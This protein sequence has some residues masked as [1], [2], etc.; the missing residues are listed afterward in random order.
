MRD[1]VSLDER[2]TSRTAYRFLSEVT[3]SK[4]QTYED[5]CNN[6]IKLLKL[7]LGKKL[8][9]SESILQRLNDYCIVKVFRVA[10]NNLS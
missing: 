9:F 3:K 7:F 2:T 5:I 1:L 10:I 6:E 4:F 8:S